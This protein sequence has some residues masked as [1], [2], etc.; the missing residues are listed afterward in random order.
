MTT[1][2]LQ[3]RVGNE[4]DTLLWNIMT[5]IH[6][7]HGLWSRLRSKTRALEKDS[8]C[9]Y[10][11][12]CSSR[13]T[14]L[15]PRGLYSSRLLCP[16]DFPARI[17]EWVTISYSR[18]SSRPMDWTHVSWV[19]WTGRWILYHWATRETSWEIHLSSIPCSITS[20]TFDPDKYFMSVLCSFFIFLMPLTLS[21]CSEHVAYSDIW[22]PAT[23]RGF[24]TVKV[25][26]Y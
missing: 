5:R 15:R 16:W 11:L 18:G 24:N 4:T 23:H 1:P 17:L 19:S 10:L 7:L 22:R 2:F 12:S 9:A 8:V 26:F 13:L 21:R 14:L 25:N 20:L 3:G 6:E